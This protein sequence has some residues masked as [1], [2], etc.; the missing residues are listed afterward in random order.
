MNDKRLSRHGSDLEYRLSIQVQ[1]PFRLAK[2]LGKKQETMTAHQH[3]ASIR[4]FHASR[5]LRLVLDP[6]ISLQSR[7]F[8][9]RALATNISGNK[10][11]PRR[12]TDKQ[13][14]WTHGHHPAKRPNFSLTRH[15]QLP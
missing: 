6:M 15:P 2:S 9:D 13:H 11:N 8:I 3:P 7:T 5:L 14:Q 10:D 4:Q 1:L 12:Q